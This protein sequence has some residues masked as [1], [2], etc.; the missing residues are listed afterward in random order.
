M[1]QPSGRSCEISGCQVC[2]TALRNR[3]QHIGI[4]MHSSILPE[5]HVTSTSHEMWYV[6]EAKLTT[7]SMAPWTGPDNLCAGPRWFRGFSNWHAVS[8]VKA[9]SA[10]PASILQRTAKSMAAS[11]ILL[12]HE[13]IWR[14]LQNHDTCGCLRTRTS[15]IASLRFLFPAPV[16]GC[17]I[18]QH[19]QKAAFRVPW[20]LKCSQILLSMSCCWRCVWDRWPALID[21]YVAKAPV[22]T[23]AGSLT[24][25]LSGMCTVI[26]TTAGGIFGSESSV[27]LSITL[28]DWLELQ[29]WSGQAHCQHQ[30]LEA[31]N[32]AT[33]AYDLARRRLKELPN[34]VL[35]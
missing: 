13:I 27:V 24:P 18:L 8:F 11:W 28:M 20:V 23:D 9:K 5:W 14:T 17:S 22:Q 10:R 4:V 34:S 30:S 29:A 1:V 6:S 12:A 15:A 35:C 16:S 26:M 32:H 19:W 3:W 7:V 2:S 33:S 25:S 21:V 31:R